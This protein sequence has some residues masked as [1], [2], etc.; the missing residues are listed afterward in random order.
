MKAI[1]KAVTETGDTATKKALGEARATLAACLSLSGAVTPKAKA[2]R[3]G[4]VSQGGPSPEPEKVLAYLAKH[5]GSSGEDAARALGTDTA[6]PRPVLHELKAAGAV[7][8]SGKGR[9]T[10]YAAWQGLPFRHVPLHGVVV[11]R[12]DDPVPQ[13]Q[14]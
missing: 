13:G 12:L 5:P 3:S 1:D 10:R 2:V 4:R 8:T 11:D 7:T 6:T 9:G 14:P